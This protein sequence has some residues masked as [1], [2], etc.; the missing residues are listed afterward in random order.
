[1]IFTNYGD[2]KTK[3]LHFIRPEVVLKSPGNNQVKG[4]EDGERNQAW[5]INILL[6][7]EN[8]GENNNINNFSL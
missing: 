7:S 1:M 5:E 2:K 4:D 3:N 8:K 6:N